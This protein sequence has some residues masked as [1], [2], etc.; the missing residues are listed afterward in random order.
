MK[1]KKWRWY[2]FLAASVGMVGLAIY[3][4]YALTKM[5][6]EGGEHSVTRV[7]ELAYELAGKWG[8]VAIPLS[9]ALLCLV[10]GAIVFMDSLKAPEPDV[11]PSAEALARGKASAEASTCAS[12]GGPV[13]GAPMTWGRFSGN[14]ELGVEDV[15]A[16]QC[17]RCGAFF[18]DE[19]KRE[20]LAFHW[21]HGW[22]KTRCPVCSALFGPG[23]VLL[24]G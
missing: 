1:D 15:A 6:T 24:K 14:K 3:E 12:C 8:V 11:E 4:H 9:I 22:E 5:E 17:R 19:C 21:W 16:F 10:A 13:D 18:C 23:G 20:K 2:Y 7:E